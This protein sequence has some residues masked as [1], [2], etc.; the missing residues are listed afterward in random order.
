MDFSTGL[1]PDPSEVVN[2]F[3]DVFAASEG[4]EEGAVIGAFVQDL[5]SGTPSAD[6]ILCSAQR[7]Q[8]LLGC[9]IFSRMTFPQDTRHVF[10]LSPMA[11]RTDSQKTG[12]GQA[13]ISFGLE[14][15]RASGANVALTYGD[16]AYY[17]KTGFRQITEATAQPPLKL[18]HPHG[19]LGQPLDGQ[20]LNPLRGPSECVSAL[21]NPSLW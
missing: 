15:L 10:I 8:V 19:W 17:S 4:P 2:L 1:P 6:L 20:E 12:V 16:P 13:L 9:A 21:N 14:H 5:I 11:V 18:S 3:A 7:D